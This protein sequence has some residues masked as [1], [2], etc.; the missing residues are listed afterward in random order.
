METSQ[1]WLINECIQC[2][3]LFK[4]PKVLPVTNTISCAVRCHPCHVVCV[5]PIRV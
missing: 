1:R 5:S 2:D 4:R 3:C